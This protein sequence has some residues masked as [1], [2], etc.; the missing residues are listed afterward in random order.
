MSVPSQL[1]RRHQVFVSSTYKDLVDER[2]EV[3]QVLLELDCMPAGM[4]LFPAADETQLRYIKR[5]IDESDYYLVI[6][7]GKYGSISQEHGL[8]YTELEYRYAIEMNKPIIGFIRE[9]IGQLA[10]N[11]TETEPHRR[12][13][14]AEFHELLKKKLCKFYTSPQDL[15]SKVS[16]AITQL[17]KQHPSAGWIRAEALEHFADPSD[18]LRLTQE[19]ERL[20]SRVEL[21]DYVAGLDLEI[22]S[23]GDELFQVEFEYYVSNDA[24][25]PL[26]TCVGQQMLSW[27]EIFRLMG[28][29]WAENLLPFEWRV[30]GLADFVKRISLSALEAKH[31]LS[32]VE[33]G[34][35]TTSTNQSI[36]IQFLALGLIEYA[37]E[38]DEIA[39]TN[40]GARLLFQL[41]ALQKPKAALSN[42]TK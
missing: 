2:A 23:S 31:T 4:E 33:F 12:Q 29:V 22:L 42:A 17:R 16:R 24:V 18:L 26:I 20:K 21:S 14:L 10:S 13:Q 32:N 38:T 1:D 5:I 40:K 39:L 41:L 9:D 3:M 15:G 6:S 37:R 25:E 28:P 19:N 34:R 35:L 30:D 8:S 36:Y 7:A 11:D 27:N